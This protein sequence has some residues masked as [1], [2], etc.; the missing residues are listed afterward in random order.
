MTEGT[1]RKVTILNWVVRDGISKVAV[2]LWH[3]R[4]KDSSRQGLGWK[5]WIK[6]A[7]CV[8]EQQNCEL[9]MPR[10]SAQRQDQR[11]GN[12]QA[13]MAPQAS[14]CED[15]LWKSLNKRMKLRKIL[16]T[17]LWLLCGYWTVKELCADLSMCPTHT[18]LFTDFLKS[19]F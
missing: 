2:E 7:W 16:K 3:E 19:N 9:R 10:N 1:W 14:R 6:K 13:V 8:L 4:Y 11:E 15:K 17:L 18:L 12:I 5:P